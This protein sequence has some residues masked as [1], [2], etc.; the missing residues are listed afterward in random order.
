MRSRLLL[1]L[2]VVAALAIPLPAFADET[3]RAAC[4]PEITLTPPSGTPGTVVSV[5]IRHYP[6]DTDVTVILRV[7]GDPVVGIGRTDVE[8]RAYVI[9]TMPSFPGD[10]VNVFATAPPCNSTGAHFFYR[11]TPPTPVP[12]ARPTATPFVPAPPTPTL[13][14]V[15]PPTPPPPAA[16]AGLFTGDAM[17][18]NMALIAL[19]LVVF[20]SGF[21]LWGSSRRRRPA[22]ATVQVTDHIASRAAPEP[23]LPGVEETPTRLLADTSR[24]R[25]SGL[26]MLAAGLG[27]TA[28]GLMLLVRGR[29]K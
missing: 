24:P 19:A 16:G 1:A 2:A 21:A 15:I 4:G 7:T 22:Y 20:S 9:F 23:E 11:E 12:T 3:P 28:A 13:P 17:T 27:A 6:P 25:G 29:R 8:G 26:S 18:F 14:P 5:N 10:Y